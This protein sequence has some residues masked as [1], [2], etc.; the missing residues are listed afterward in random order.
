MA[1]NF[2][3][4]VSPEARKL[5]LLKENKGAGT[6]EYPASMG[7][8]PLTK[9]A[10]DSLKSSYEKNKATAKAEFE[11][12]KKQ[13]TK[14]AKDSGDPSPK[15]KFDEETLCIDIEYGFK[16]CMDRFSDAA[17]KS[18]RK[19]LG[20][21][22][23]NAKYQDIFMERLAT[24]EV[25]AAY[26]DQKA[27]LYQDY[28]DPNA[29]KEPSSDVDVSKSKTPTDALNTIFATQAGMCLNDNHAQ[30][31]G[32]KFLIDNMGALKKAKVDTLFIEHFWQEQQD[33]L[34]EYMSAPDDA[35]LPKALA[36][37]VEKLDAEKGF[38]GVP[39]FKNLLAAAKKEKIRIVGL[40]SFMAK[41]PQ[42]NDP[43]T[44]EHRAAR[45]NKPASEVVEREKGKG[46]FLL[47]AGTKH[48]NTH[49]GGI[50]G[51]AQ[52]LGVHNFEATGGKLVK[53]PE[54]KKQRGMR[55]EPL[56]AFFDGFIDKFHKESP[57]S[58]LE[59]VWEDAEKFA[60]EQA[61][62]VDKM[63][64]ANAEKLGQIVAAR[65][66]KQMA[67]DKT[68]MDTKV[69]AGK[70]NAAAK[71]L[72]SLLHIAAEA[73]DL[74]LVTE[75]I[76]AG[77]SA[78][79]VDSEGN[80]PLHKLLNGTNK[81][82][83][84]VSKLLINNGA[85]LATKNKANIT[86]LHQAL[87][88]NY[89]TPP[90]AD[91][92]KDHPADFKKASAVPK[93]NLKVIDLVMARGDKALEDEMYQKGVVDDP[94]LEV[95]DSNPKTTSEILAM[96]T[97]CD[98]EKIRPDVVK[99]YQQLYD[100]YPEF[101]STLDLA[102][103]S[104]LGD[105]KK[106]KALRFIMVNDDNPGKVT[107][108]G[109]YG[110]YDDGNTTLALGIRRD[111]KTLMGTLIHELTH[112]AVN[113]LYDNDTMPIPKTDPGNK[114][115]KQYLGSLESDVKNSALAL[116]PE[117]L[118]FQETLN[119]RLSGYVN[120]A[121][122]PKR[123]VR[124]HQEYVVGAPQLLVTHGRDMLERRGGGVLNFWEQEI[125]PSCQRTI[126]NHPLKA[127]LKP[128]PSDGK[129]YDPDNPWC[130]KN[131]FKPEAISEAVM[132][133][134]RLE[135]GCCLK[136]FSYDPGAE[137]PT[138][139]NA[140]KLPQEIALDKTSVKPTDG[141]AELKKAL[142]NIVGN[143]SYSKPGWYD[144]IRT[145]A[146]QA[147][148]AKNP[149]RDALA[150]AIEDLNKEIEKGN[151]EAKLFR[152]SRTKAQD[153]LT[154]ELAK[155]Q[156]AGKLPDQLHSEVLGA[157]VG[158]TAG[159]IGAGKLSDQQVGQF[160]G[161][162]SKSTGE[163]TTDLKTAYSRKAAVDE[164]AKTKA[165]LRHKLSNDLLRTPEEFAEAA[166]LEAESRYYRA[167]P[168]GNGVPIE[169][170]SKKHRE[171]VQQIAATIKKNGAVAKTDFDK[172]VGFVE[173]EVLYT[174]GKKLVGQRD[175]SHVSIAKRKEWVKKLGTL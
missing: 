83:G 166:V 115:E 169:V 123:R 3:I 139:L 129:P 77:Q 160:E 140:F 158:K 16:E 92:L 71:K 84:A 93:G 15:L 63:T 120:K 161:F 87:G 28:R 79:S 19:L 163:L 49:E 37:A 119:G 5:K 165:L 85:S 130:G 56:Q 126:D 167:N 148:A 55:S 24:P 101:R 112:H 50:P 72:G 7:L 11:A 95:K 121:T 144:A 143:T 96:A 150:K 60:R 141:V 171:L 32:K 43:R 153:A 174:K 80:T 27:K 30:V 91:W 146:E 45:F 124:A 111:P 81:D 8:P 116:T 18:I 4:Q 2:Q 134:I 164:R 98:D 44:K 136:T 47:M 159:Q 170:D 33:L 70:L 39:Y 21:A 12:L 125:R 6:Y 42:D 14:D 64:P 175:Q 23:E 108:K 131:D 114:V 9:P 13:L 68:A 132:N 145:K 151:A 46:K 94:P 29:Y 127:K 34:D 105:R 133:K 10:Y 65:A 78:S 54:D 61:A 62:T 106:D 88:I 156:K 76:A 86:P 155:A 82:P 41:T 17:K 157:F 168:P 109:G 137:P 57:K 122:G 103:L 58:D 110:A 25:K 173:N 48:N 172:Y 104:A 102:A 90:F 89:G 100:D 40:D 67:E 117:E 1:T 97:V 22:D 138:D 135:N 52:L 113:T 36:V 66:L 152:E 73:N 99:Y 38:K 149:D 118:K 107:T 142:E 31:D 26:K 59:A 75:L 147:L 35:E 74:A 20:I 128:R 154:K 162:V 51:M 69:D 53:D